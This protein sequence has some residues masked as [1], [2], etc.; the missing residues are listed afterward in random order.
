MV[1][2]PGFHCWGR[3]WAWIRS[4]V[5]ELRSHVPCG[6]AKKNK[7]KALV[8]IIIMRKI[9]LCFLCSEIIC[10][11]YIGSRRF[12]STNSTHTNPRFFSPHSRNSKIKTNLMVMEEE[13]FF[14][15]GSSGIGEQ[16]TRDIFIEQS[17]RNIIYL[18]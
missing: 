9:I 4:L 14:F 8:T 12:N 17:K 5:R 6:M 15:S 18:Y 1:R 16:K 10:M 2:T 11:L 7:I 3:G 13:E